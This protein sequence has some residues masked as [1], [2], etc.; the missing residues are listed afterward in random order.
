M[1]I[2]FCK[3][4]KK[5]KNGNLGRVSHLPEAIMLDLDANGHSP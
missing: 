1:W 5:K 4:K 2:L 3:K